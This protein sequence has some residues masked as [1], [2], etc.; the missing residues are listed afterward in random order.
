MRAIGTRAGRSVD[1]IMCSSGAEANI[2]SAHC[3]VSE[4]G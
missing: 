3:K 2:V 1:F 4:K